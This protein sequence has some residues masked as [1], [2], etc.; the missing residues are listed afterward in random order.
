M[1]ARRA[2]AYKRT[3]SCRSVVPRGGEKEGRRDVPRAHPG[4]L[5]EPLDRRDSGDL[6]SDMFTF[7]SISDILL[8]LSLSFPLYLSFSHALSL[9]H[10]FSPLR[11]SSG[12]LV[13]RSRACSRRDAFNRFF[14]LVARLRSCPRTIGNT[15]R[16]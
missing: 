3:P 5:A 16:T 10:S 14:L 2:H 1:Q 12:L 6:P 11:R 8:L 13:P 15:R 7:A 9:P 4:L